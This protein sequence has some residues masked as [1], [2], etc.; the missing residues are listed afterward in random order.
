VDTPEAGQPSAAEARGFALAYLARREHSCAELSRKLQQRG[1][2]GAT[3]AGVVEELAGEGLIS[4]RRY[5]EVFVRQRI[6]RLYGP[7]RIR[8]DLQTRGV[9]AAIIDENLPGDDE[10]WLESA[11]EWIGRR[12]RRHLDRKERARLYRSACNRGFTHQQAMRALDRLGA[13]P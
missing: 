5:A 10:L 8:A 3:A 9:A 6:R 11:L 4:D 2:D 7:L 12:A 13:E 1:V